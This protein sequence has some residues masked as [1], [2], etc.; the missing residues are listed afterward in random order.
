MRNLTTEEFE[1]VSGG[2]GIAG[3]AVPTP[4]SSGTA[5]PTNGGGTAPLLPQILPFV[6]LVPNTAASPPSPSPPSF[7]VL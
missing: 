3:S 7:V 2:S 6:V 4:P 5:P 1:Y